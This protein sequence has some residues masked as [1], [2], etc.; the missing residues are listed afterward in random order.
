M[1]PVATPVEQNQQQQAP[2][3]APIDPNTAGDQTPVEQTPIDATTLTQAQQ[4][5]N[6]PAQSTPSGVSNEV[7]TNI[8]KINQGNEQTA[9]MAQPMSQKEQIQNRIFEILGAQQN[10]ATQN[11]QLRKDAQLA[12]KEERARKL[13]NEIT[14]RER[15]YT[16]KVRELEKNPEGK[17]AGGLEDDLNDLRREYNSEQADLAIQY[18]VALGDYQ[19]AEK[20]V[21]Q[22]ISDIE[23][24]YANQLDTLQV[25]YNFLQN[26]MTEGEKMQAQQKFALLQDQKRFDQE[27]AMLAYKATLEQS[28]PM[29]QA[30][31]AQTRAQTAAIRAKTQGESASVGQASMSPLASALAQSNVSMVDNLLKDKYLSSAVGVNPLARL[32]PT[33]LATGG[34]GNFIASVEQL[35][36]QLS[37]DSLINAK[38]RGATFGA[39]SD[40]ELRLLSASATKIGT[41]A[42][43]KDGKTVGYS[44]SPK[45]FKK[46][47][48]KINNFAKID[49]IYRGGNPT[50]V[51]AQIMPD[52]TVWTKNYDGTLTLLLK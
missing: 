15:A 50:D 29:Y 43:V 28:D 19:A 13:S 11:E 48:D 1:P 9:A 44:A 25:A 52:K 17:F 14:A 32:S 42:I 38:A 41:W 34:K 3:P 45:E 47:L 49:Y 30:N 31:L 6:P 21:S 4:G 12:K 8:E 35:R 51:G 27:K 5:Y 22:Q 16:K 26:D 18:N 40:A 23:K 36:S 39:L 37:L 2:L 46:E 20:I 7:A 33:S 24:S 10:Q